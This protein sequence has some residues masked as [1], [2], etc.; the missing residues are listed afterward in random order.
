LRISAKSLGEALPDACPRCLWVSL[1]FDLPYQRFP[2]VFSTIDR[3]IKRAVHTAF[4]AGGRLPAWFPDI[5]QVA[6]YEQD[7]SVRRFRVAHP[8]TGVVLTGVPDDVFRMAGDSYHIVD[9]KTAKLTEGQAAY[10]PIYEVQLNAYAYIAERIG[11]SPVRALSLV[12]MQ[13]NADHDAGADAG[14]ALPFEATRVH[15][16]L[17]HEALIPPLLRTAHETFGLTK[18]PASKEGCEDCVRL[19]SL[20]H[21]LA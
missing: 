15:V 6:A 18:P 8:D 13:P 5:G 12:Y 1:H 3:F 16:D 17:K 7:L 4:D 2:G 21:G 20:V 19:D 9:Y 14:P 10:L 11:L